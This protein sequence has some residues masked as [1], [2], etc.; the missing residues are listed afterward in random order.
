MVAP[1]DIAVVGCGPAGMAAALFLT[2]AGHRVRIFERFEAPRPVGAGLLLQPSGLSVLR[3][4][5]LLPEIVATGARIN[6]LDGTALPSGRK[7]L[8]VAYAEL[9]G[10]LHGIGIHRA[11]L[12]DALF[13]AV[14]EAD[15]EVVTTTAIAAVDS[16]AGQRPI[17]VDKAGR[18]YGPFDLAVDASGAQSNLRRALSGAAPTPFLYGALWTTVALEGA[19]FDPTVLVQRYVA[20]RQMVGV[21]PVGA[22]PEA[23]GPHA[24]FFWSMARSRLDDWRLRGVAA[25][26]ADVAAIWPEAAAL[27]SPIDRP[28]QMQPAFYVHYTAGSPIGPRLALLGDAAHSTSPQL[29][30]GANM[31]LLDALA[32]AEAAAEYADIDDALTAY[33]AARRRHVRFYQAASW[34]LTPLFQSDSRAAAVLRDLA[35]PCLAHIPYFRRET[36]RSLAGLKTGLFTSL[37]LRSAPFLAVR[38]A[39]AEPEPLPPGNF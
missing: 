19:G 10:D 16:A 33:A 18:R 26:K 35:F 31:G 7:I 3:R 2:R 38:P 29:G 36:V 25:W 24:A 39:A 32:L 13:R 5:G 21:M 28:D 23:D 34:W 4:L 20:A 14:G 1:S 22:A 15:I 8:D 37:D 17:L 6:R 11:S 12:F 30:Q 9:G 27:L